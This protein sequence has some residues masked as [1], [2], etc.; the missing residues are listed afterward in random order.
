MKLLHASRQQRLMLDR[1]SPSITGIKRT[2]HIEH[3]AGSMCAKALAGAA[4]TVLC[5]LQS[6]GISYCMDLQRFCCLLIDT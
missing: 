2:L 4:A 1:Q 5:T 6:D 3:F